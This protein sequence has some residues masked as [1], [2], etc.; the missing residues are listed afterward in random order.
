[1]SGELHSL[2]WTDPEGTQHLEIQ[3]SPFDEQFKESIIRL[4]KGPAAVMGM[5]KEVL[6]TDS[7]DCTNF[8]W[9]DGKVIFPTKEYMTN[10]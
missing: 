4:T 9:R 1:M 3:L 7:G 2:Y 5:V 10:G 6:V 8:L